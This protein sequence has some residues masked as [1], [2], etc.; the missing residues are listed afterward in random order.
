MPGENVNSGGKINLDLLRLRAQEIRRAAN[1]L[2][3]YSNL[4]RE[5]FVSDQMMVD[6]AKY[7]LL[8]AM[9]QRRQFALT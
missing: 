6:A 4:S 2:A 1:V 5:E 7:R 8:V 9:K 3:G